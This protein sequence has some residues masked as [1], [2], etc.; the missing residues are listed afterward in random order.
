MSIW[1]GI[2]NTDVKFSDLRS[3]FKSSNSGQVSLSNFYRSTT[4]IGWSDAEPNSATTGIYVRPFNTGV[5]TSGTIAFSDFKGAWDGVGISKV[6]IHIVRGNSLDTIYL[7]VNGRLATHDYVRLT[8]FDSIT[9]WTFTWAGTTFTVDPGEIVDTT[10]RI[11]APS[12][13]SVQTGPDTSEQFTII[14][15]S[16]QQDTGIT[17]NTVTVSLAGWSYPWNSLAIRPRIGFFTT[18]S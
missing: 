5:P 1:T 4:E 9:D 10:D 13:I 17:A 11:Y 3:T 7:A 12:N 6:Y 15:F 16:T 14:P 8:D 18:S 2:P